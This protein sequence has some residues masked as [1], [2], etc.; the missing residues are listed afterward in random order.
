MMGLFGTAVVAVGFT[1]VSW[2]AIVGIGG[3]QPTERFVILL[4]GWLCVVWGVNWI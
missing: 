1:A 3:D 2:M 4:I